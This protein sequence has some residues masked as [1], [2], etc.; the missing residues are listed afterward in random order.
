MH[1]PF[2]F[3]TTIE[4]YQALPMKIVEHVVGQFRDGVHGAH[5]RMKEE[6]INKLFQSSILVGEPHIPWG[7]FNP[8]LNMTSSVGCPMYQTPTKYWPQNLS[9]HYFGNRTVFGVL[10]DPYERL[11]AMF[12]G[13]AQDYGHFD[14]KFEESCDVNGAIKALM[15]KILA[16][17]ESF[18]NHCAFLA[19]SDYFE[20]Y[21][22]IRLPIDGRRF[23]TSL[24]EAFKAHGYEQRINSS[25]IF[26]PKGCDDVWAGDLDDETKALVKKVYSG[27][28]ELI[29]KHFNH[30]DDTENV[31][32]HEIPGNCPKKVSQ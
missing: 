12:R 3:G 19:Q 8:S 2:T 9:H 4:T 29:C 1:I 32:I 26:H 31:C 18:G 7:E 5:W 22:G 14:K 28:F 15:T 16:E 6:F 20:G 24:N 13:D 30:C 25:L 11:V 23:P 17:G 10:R 27:D 21:Y